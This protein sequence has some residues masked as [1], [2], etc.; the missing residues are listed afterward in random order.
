MKKYAGLFGVF[1]F[2]LLS[3]SCW[4]VITL[5]SAAPSNRNNS[6]SN[7]VT[8]AGIYNPEGN[9]AG[10]LLATS[11]RRHSRGNRFTQNS[12][13]DAGYLLAGYSG[14]RHN[15]GRTV[16]LKNSPINTGT[17]LAQRGRRHSRGNHPEDLKDSP[18]DAGYLLARSG[19]RHSRGDYP[20]LKDLPND[21]GTLLAQRGRRHSRGRIHA[22][23][24]DSTSDS[25]GS[26]TVA[27]SLEIQDGS[28]G[29]RHS[30]GNH[31]NLKDSPSDTGTLLA[32]G[33]GYGRRHSRGGSYVV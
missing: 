6:L 23:A 32:P 7:T 22:E 27:N 13:S 16:G 9:F 31:Q 28:F 1:G 29:R 17:L 12:P 26:F 3:L 2:V 21:T 20:D 10:Y 33:P 25:A 4:A 11:G 14:R 19:R 8:K 5:V 30:R 24:K 15:R 18:S